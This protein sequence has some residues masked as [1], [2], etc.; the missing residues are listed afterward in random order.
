MKRIVLISILL[1]FACSKDKEVAKNN[2][3]TAVRLLPGTG[4]NGGCRGTIGY[5]GYQEYV[6]LDWLGE[7]EFTEEYIIFHSEMNESNFS[8]I[9]RTSEKSYRVTGLDYGKPH[10][11]YVVPYS[12]KF[13]NGPKSEVIESYRSQKYELTELIQETT[14]KGV[15]DFDLAN[16]KIFLIN[17]TETNRTLEIADATNGNILS[18]QTNAIIDDTYKI[19]VNSNEEIYALSLN[20]TLIT[21][22]EANSL[23]VLSELQIDEGVDNMDISPTTDQVYLRRRNSN[24]IEVYNARLELEFEIDL[25]L[26]IDAEKVRYFILGNDGKIYTSGQDGLNESGSANY[27][28]EVRDSNGGVME[29][30]DW[31]SGSLLERPLEV[32][33]EGYVYTIKL[34]LN[35][36]T[37]IYKYRWVDGR[38]RFI[39][40]LGLFDSSD[41]F[42]IDPKGDVLRSNGSIGP[43]TVIYRLRAID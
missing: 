12:K 1:A 43:S 19:A 4:D 21:R 16:G 24:I 17:V 2:P 9:A 34:G 18:N 33:Q 3:L 35:S 40:N 15:Q 23:I 14:G 27:I 30:F 6:C 31:S 37:F 10:Y 8:E 25:N 22:L 13:G 28:L 11:F 36:T 20:T 38:L 32:D 39:G 42:K 7:S 5:R 29:I 41:T 26:N